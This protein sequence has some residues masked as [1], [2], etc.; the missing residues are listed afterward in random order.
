[1]STLNILP[2]KNIEI[3]FISK[4]VGKQYLD[5]TQNENRRLDAFYTQDAR[6]IYSWRKNRLREINFILQVN[7]IFNELYEP[8]GYSFSYIYG[9]S[10]T[11]E[12]YYYPM[13]GTNFMFGVNVKL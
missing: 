3:S 11:T 9:G 13:A 5:N 2:A 12:N 6:I 1:G 7:N 10:L 4:Y 8:N